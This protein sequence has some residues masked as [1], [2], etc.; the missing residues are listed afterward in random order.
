[1]SSMGG[2]SFPRSR[3]RS[4][5]PI[6]CQT[7]GDMLAGLFKQLWEVLGGLPG[8]VVLALAVLVVYWW[9]EFRAFRREVRQAQA[10]AERDRKAAEE[11]AKE[12]RE[13]NEREHDR[14][15]TAV[16]ALQAVV[17]SLQADVR[18]LLDRSDRSGD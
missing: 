6:L 14:L 16:S 8:T 3:S 11:R 12:D 5:L 15:F 13:R 4:S 1:M 18:V 7:K 2:H 9:V 17:A 10:Q